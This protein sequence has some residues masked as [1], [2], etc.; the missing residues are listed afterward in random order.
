MQRIKLSMTDYHFINND[1]RYFMWFHLASWGMP[2]LETIAAAASDSVGG[3]PVS[4]ICFVEGSRNLVMFV[5]LPLL[6][7]IIVGAGFLSA[8]MAAIWQV[9]YYSATLKD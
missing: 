5:V 4:G 8:G 6:V 1:S 3:D 2:L 9:G 7:K